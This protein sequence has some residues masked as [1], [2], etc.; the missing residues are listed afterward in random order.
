MTQLIYKR[1]MIF[2]K[3]E[4]SILKA[5]LHLGQATI[6]QIGKYTQINRTS[7]YPIIQKLEEK[8]IVS[9]V[10]NEGVTV[11]QSLSKPALLAWAKRKEAEYTKEISVFS[12]WVETQDEVPSL[13][14][15]VKHVTGFD[16]VKALYDHSWRNNEDKQILAITDYKQAYDVMGDFFRKDYF[17]KRVEKGISVQSILPESKIGR[18]DKAQAKALKR[19]MRFLPLFEE[20]GIELNIYDDNV[21]I[22]AFDAE[23]PS[24]VIITNSIIAKAFKEIFTVLWKHGKK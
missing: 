11:Y 5:L 4:Q 9:A 7:I 2:T 14:T 10:T 18:K 16:G 1:G 23:R 20:L 24:G 19:D 8:G 6:S 22:V 17:H 21:S 13:A 12:D 15:E 3:K